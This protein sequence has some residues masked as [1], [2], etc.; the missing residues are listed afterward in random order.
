MKLPHLEVI[1]A[2]TP[3][4]NLLLWKYEDETK[5]LNND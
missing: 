3:N 5:K 4:P 2:T 1:E